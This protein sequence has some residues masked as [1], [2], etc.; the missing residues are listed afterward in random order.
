MPAYSA[1]APGKVILFGEHAVVYGQPALAV[2]VAD[3]TAKVRIQPAPDLPRGEVLLTAPAV[4]LRDASLNSLPENDPLAKAVRLTLEAVGAHMPA[5]RIWISSTI[6]VAAGLGSGAAVSVALVRA[7]SGFLGK[8]LPPQTISAIAYEVEKIHH[9]TPSGIDNTVITYAQPVYFV[10]G[11]PIRTF[12]IAKPFTLVIADSGVPAPTAEAVADVRR[13]YQA[14]PERYGALF[15]AIGRVVERARAAIVG[16]AVEDLGAL[17]DENQRLLEQIGVSCPTLERLIAAA[18]QAGA[19]GAK[20]SGGGRG[21]N[22]IALVPPQNPTLAGAIAEAL[23]AAG[24]V[25]TIV[26][27][28]K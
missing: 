23:R 26:S 1:S 11:E 21:G 14:E 17:M 6:P 4:G 15:A 3:V 19:L 20:L 12:S 10:R 22:L 7:V 13:A 8:P 27:V 9:G 18:K 5:A 16:G 24:A 2:P 28:V 25:R